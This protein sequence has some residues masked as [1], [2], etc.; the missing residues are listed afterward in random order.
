MITPTQE[1]NVLLRAHGI[2]NMNLWL[3]WGLRLM[4]FLKQGLGFRVFR[5][6]GLGFRVQGLGFKV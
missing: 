2:P 3:A 4:S 6:E 1:R 5:V